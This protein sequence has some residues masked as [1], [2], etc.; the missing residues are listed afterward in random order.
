MVGINTFNSQHSGGRCR[1]ISLSGQLGPHGLVNQGYIVKCCL[2]KKLKNRK[3][4]IT[5]YF[6]VVA[7]FLLG[8][9][10]IS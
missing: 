9:Q 4:T 3:S 8:V 10:P 5:K 2:K 1:L 6:F 7:V